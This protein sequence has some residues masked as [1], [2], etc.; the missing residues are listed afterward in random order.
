MVFMR[1]IPPQPV[2]THSYA[3]SFPFIDSGTVVG[4][5]TEDETVEVTTDVGMELTHVRVMVPKLFDEDNGVSVTSGKNTAYIDL[6]PIGAR[7]IIGYIYGKITHP[8]IL[9]C[10]YDWFRHENTT[11]STEIDRRFYLHQSHYWDKVNG[12][13]N[14]EQYFPDGSKISVSDSISDIN[15]I[16][17]EEDRYKLSTPLTPKNIRI[18]HAT[19]TVIQIKPDGTV[20]I[21]AA[22]I[23]LGDDNATDGL[24]LGSKFRSIFNNHIHPTGVGPSGTPIQNPLYPSL[25]KEDTDSSIVDIVE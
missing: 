13:G 22:K 12:V 18:E 3:K 2:Q 20:V 21:K 5:N 4:I 10:V 23:E 16:L 14:W 6:P 15:S 24:V 1:H 9:G 19:G 8:V 7:V 17:S 25:T 11:Q